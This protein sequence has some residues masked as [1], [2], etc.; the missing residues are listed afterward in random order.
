[1][2][3][4]QGRTIQLVSTLAFLSQL[5]LF[6]VNDSAVKSVKQSCFDAMTRPVNKQ[7]KPATGFGLAWLEA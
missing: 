5:I 3:A 7:A 4:H 1:M 6:F 2:N